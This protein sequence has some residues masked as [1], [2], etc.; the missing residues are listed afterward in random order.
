M[1]WSASAALGVALVIGL[2]A[3][4]PG[5]VLSSKAPSKP[6]RK[7]APKGFPVPAKP[8]ADTPPPPPLTWLTA[9]QTTGGG[10]TAKKGMLQSFVSGQQTLKKARRAQRAARRRVAAITAHIAALNKDLA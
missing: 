9:A 5:A 10:V 7:A 8:A 2:A 1:R 3:P 6:P 4:A